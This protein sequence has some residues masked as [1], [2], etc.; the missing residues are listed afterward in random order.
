MTR[1][2]SD[3]QLDEQQTLIEVPPPTLL[4]RAADLISQGICAGLSPETIADQ[5][6]ALAR[7]TRR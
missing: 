3:T 1:F 2:A 6:L 4:E 5:I 7:P